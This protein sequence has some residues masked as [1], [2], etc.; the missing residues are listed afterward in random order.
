MDRRPDADED[1]PLPLPSSSSAEKRRK[2][3]PLSSTDDTSNI[4]PQG[5]MQ[6]TLTV[7]YSTTE[8]REE[9]R[10]VHHTLPLPTSG[11]STVGEHMRR[12]KQVLGDAQETVNA[13]LTAAMPAAT[14]ADGAAAADGAE[15]DEDESGSEVG[16]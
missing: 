12:L 9:S 11:D 14:A 16:V 13:F 8:G 7:T 10:L 1:P 5:V 15:V 6:H 4:I 2:L 3:L